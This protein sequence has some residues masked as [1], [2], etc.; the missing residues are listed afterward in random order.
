M[1]KERHHADLSAGIY[2][3]HVTSCIGKDGSP[4]LFID[5]DVPGLRVRVNDE[6]VWGY[7]DA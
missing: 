3:V 6:L 2:D 7:G 4:V 5:G 1:G